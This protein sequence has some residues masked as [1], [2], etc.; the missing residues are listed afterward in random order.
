MDTRAGTSISPRGGHSFPSV[1]PITLSCK[2]GKQRRRAAF[3]RRFTT[4]ARPL[5][6]RP[7]R[8]RPFFRR[9]S[10]P[11]RP[12]F[13]LVRTGGCVSFS[14]HLDSLEPPLSQ[15]FC[16]QPSAPSARKSKKRRSAC[17]D[18]RGFLR[19][20]PRFASTLFELASF[21]SRIH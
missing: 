6:L 2:R 8:C 4:I 21:S 3:T 1:R 14:L 17:K 11:T 16:Q 9:A 13:Q 5:N 12:L 19:W 18:H 20:P 10:P 7:S 15:T